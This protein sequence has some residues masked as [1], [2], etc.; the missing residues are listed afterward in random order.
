MKIYI[1]INSFLRIQLQENTENTYGLQNVQTT[2]DHL[3]KI[4]TRN[5][6][7][8]EYEI[9]ISINILHIQY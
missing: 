9:L 1:Q 4:N 8:N 2:I 7:K 3:Y 6:K 5:Y